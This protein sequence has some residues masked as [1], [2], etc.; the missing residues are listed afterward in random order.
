MIE[1]LSV[2]SNYASAGGTELSTLNVIQ[3]T[4]L[5]RI[6]GDDSVSINV[7]K[8]EW[9]NIV[10]AD[11]RLV[12]RLEWTEGK[13]EEFRINKIEG[14]DL[15]DVVRLFGVPVFAELVTCG[16]VYT[17]LAGVVTTK[18]SGELTI[19][20]WWTNYVAT[21][22]GATSY[23]IVLGT[24]EVDS[25]VPLEYDNTTP[26]Q[27]IRD[28]ASKSG[29]EVQIVRT[30]EST[31]TVNFKLDIGNSLPEVDVA[32]GVNLISRS[33]TIDEKD[34]ITVVVPL[35]D[36]DNA[37]GDRPTIAN[38]K[39]RIESITGAGPY[40]VV[41]YDRSSNMGPIRVDTQWQG[42]LIVWPNGNTSAIIESRASD[43]SV[44]VSSVFGAVAGNFIGLRSGNGSAIT[45]IYDAVSSA[46][47]RKRTAV[48]RLSGQRG[49]RNEILNGRFESGLSNW[50]ALN[51]TSPAAYVEV[52]RAEL[53]RT[54]TGTASA[55][56]ASTGTGTPLSL[57]IGNNEWVRQAD[58]IE[59]G[60]VVLSVPSDVIPNN[61]GA[62]SIPVSS[63]G[64]PGN[65]ASGTAFN[66]VRREIRTWLLD[67]DQSILASSLKFRDSG[68][69]QI[70][71]ITHVTLT[72]SVGGHAVTSSCYVNYTSGAGLLAGKVA[73]TPFSAFPV[74]IL[75]AASITG[76]IFKALC[77]TA[78][79]IAS[80]GLSATL[81]VSGYTGAFPGAVIGTTRLRW[82]RD[83]GSWFVVRVTAIAGGTLTLVPEG[84]AII[85]NP[86]S[87]FYNSSYGFWE[88]DVSNA[89]LS[90]GSTWTATMTRETR[91]MTL[92]GAHP[93]GALIL[94][95]NAQTNIATR[96]WLSTD[97]VTLTRTLTG[98][99]DLTV[100]GSPTPIYYYDEE[101]D[102]NIL[103]GWEL[104]CTFAAASSTMDNVSLSDYPS[105]F[106]L[107]QSGTSG[108]WRLISITGT[109]VV[110][111]MPVGGSN[112][113]LPTGVVSSTWNKDD[114]YTLT[115]TASW[116]NNGR[117]V[118][119]LAS[120]IPAGRSYARGLPVRSNWHTSGLM[121]LH[122]DVSAGAGTIEIAGVDQ[123]FSTTSPTSSAAYAVYRVMGSGS[124]VPIPGNTMIAAA[125]AQANGSGVISV[126]I[127]AAN[128][129]PI[130]NG[131]AVKIVRPNL[132]RPTDP[133]A[134][135]VPRLL[136][137]VGGTN[138][139]NSST[140]GIRSSSYSISVPS[141]Q[142]RMLTAFVSFA[143]S[144]GTYNLGQQ[145]AIAIINADT[146]AILGSA[147]LSDGAVQ[148]VGS[149][150]WVRLICQANVSGTISVALAIYGGSS[151]TPVLWTVPIDA[152]LAVTT[153]TEVPFVE[154][155]WANM[156]AMRGIDYFLSKRIPVPNIR[157]SWWSLVSWSDS[158]SN[159]P[160][161]GQK[162]RDTDLGV[163]RRIVQ[164][165]RSLV[166]GTCQVEIGTVPTDLS[167]RVANL[168]SSQ[169]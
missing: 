1:K 148:V 98:T 61:L 6:D 100:V 62:L 67:G 157:C 5:S 109:T 137:A 47:N 57:T 115:G 49:E 159:I 39:Y 81:T 128:A 119:T 35:G 11:I 73:V 80:D 59:I 7:H 44:V 166:T 82:R 146:N 134:G 169:T 8:D 92:N 17:T 66:L 68:T 18:V 43:S 79:V 16:P 64:L 48:V 88:F 70:P 95:C 108:T 104:T 40:R 71:R 2:W 10:G 155:A 153:S 158:S 86:A 129:N 22:V 76:L 51:P 147:R 89:V 3:G 13:V 85:Q 63:P 102:Q 58:V 135:S 77:A 164:V 93:A 136:S 83:G 97:T 138:L 87:F 160:V 42:A 60:G 101:L 132:L 103:D 126:P 29:Q 124:I 25:V 45:E 123:W 116:G 78:P 23:N 122:A 167:R 41:L 54:V 94:V 99:F 121:C 91:V 33:Q 74:G 37:S 140:P 139:P 32:A 75:D 145:P 127:T 149:V 162:V 141:G 21:H 38:V 156:L 150:T 30:N 15:T 50:S 55:R 69:N 163:V 46:G 154:D 105:G 133:T 19:T 144:T 56:A 120:A 125:S 152:M 112:T 20:Q 117:V 106:I 12:L 111:N 143:I 118:L 26:G 9:T 65:F 36:V 114:V 28:A 52:P 14:D 96:N 84:D 131:E 168:A 72:A 90:D 4:S 27:I 161:V 53:N 24:I 165:E 31:W 113:A 130:S 142:T 110:F 34:M 151:T 107:F